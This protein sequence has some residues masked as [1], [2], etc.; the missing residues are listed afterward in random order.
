M[1]DPVNEL[2]LDRNEEGLLR[3]GPSGRGWPGTTRPAGLGAIP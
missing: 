2:M 3:I 1:T